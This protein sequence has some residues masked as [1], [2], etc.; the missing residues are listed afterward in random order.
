MDT[1]V[2][3]TISE[4]PEVFAGRL[5][6]ELS[7]RNNDASIMNT[8]ATIATRITAPMIAG[9]FEVFFFLPLEEWPGR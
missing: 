7:G 6:F 9:A 3:V 1:G 2:L 5:G 4:L 8:A